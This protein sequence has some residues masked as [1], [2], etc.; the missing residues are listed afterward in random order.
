MAT[1]LERI[2]TRLAEVRKQMDRALA[3]RD[4][5]ITAL[6]RAVERGKIASRT[7]ARLEKQRAEARKEER[8]ARSGAAARRAEDGPVP[9]LNRLA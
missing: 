1:K 5:A 3:L 9:D 8:V 2:E 7:L 6:M 4:A